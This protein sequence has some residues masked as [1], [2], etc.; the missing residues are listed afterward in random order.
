VIRELRHFVVVTTAALLL[1]SAV[2]S[3]QVPANPQFTVRTTA[4]A[5]QGVEIVVTYDLD[6]VDADA[7]FVVTL[8]VDDGARPVVV[9]NGN[10]SGDA[11]DNIAPGRAKRIRWLVFRDVEAPALERFTYDVKVVPVIRSGN[12]EVSSV[13]AGA[14]VTIDAE[15]QPRG[16]TPL[17]ITGLPVG[18]HRVIVAKPGYIENSLPA[19]VEAGKTIVV[20]RELTVDVTALIQTPPV[21]S[22]ARPRQAGSQGGKPKWLWPLIGGG[23]AAGVFASR[24]DPPCGF[25]ISPTEFPNPTR[26]GGSTQVT[27]TVSPA[28]CGSP[29]WTATSGQFLIVQ[30]LSGTGSQVVAVSLPSNVSL[31]GRDDVA[32][33]AGKT[34]KLTAQPGL[35]HNTI[36]LALTTVQFEEFPGITVV[37]GQRLRIAAL[38]S[39]C[40]NDPDCTVNATPDGSGGIGDATARLPNVNLNS[41][42][43][44]IGG[45]TAV[46]L[47]FVGSNYD[48]NAPS[49]GSLYCGMNKQPPT[50]SNY[51]ANSRTWTVTVII[52]G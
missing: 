24:G 51:A 8:V 13:P 25:S 42:I 23:I 26:S 1:S 41:L 16:T 30:P 9:S 3:P 14:S 27:L 40:T 19:I 29:T 12:L 7:R 35:Q 47:F 18:S 6:A 21:T 17:T 37:Q 45:Q 11:G 28:G 52:G 2:V 20:S 43:C 39:V 48:K 38:G 49:G 31:D 44:G 46:E 33:I 22:P 36:S 15:T 32:T 4:H 10:V 34:F 50:G 5:R